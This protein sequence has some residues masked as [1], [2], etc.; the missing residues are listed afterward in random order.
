MRVLR[1]AWCFGAEAIARPVWF[2][3]LPCIPRNLPET[4]IKLKSLNKKE[5]ISLK[6]EDKRASRGWGRR[7]MCSYL[8]AYM[9]ALIPTVRG[10]AHT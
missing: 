4:G 8:T 1:T 9:V 7:T 5:D 6:L 2:G 10:R 3:N